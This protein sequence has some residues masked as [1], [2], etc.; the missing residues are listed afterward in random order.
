M[1]TTAALP[2]DI[3]LMNTVANVLWVGFGIALIAVVM[4]WVARLPLFAIHA[5]IVD[6]DVT[7]NS[8]TTI[9]ANAAPRLA[10]T[11]FTLDLDRAKQAFEAVPWVREAIV[12][13]VWPNRI[14]VHLE[15]HHPAAFWGDDKL[16]NTEGEVFEANLGDVEDDNLPTL[17]GPD[18]SSQ[19][20]LSLYR[21][22]EPVLEKLDTRIDTLNLSGRGSYQAELD[23]GATIEIGRGTE[24]ELV[25]R[26]QRFVRTL[27][28][29][30]THYGRSLQYADLRHA[31]GYAVRLK[32][33]TTTTD[34]QPAKPAVKSKPRTTTRDVPAKPG[35]H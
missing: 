1:D 23:N 18:G 28:E 30:T 4:A 19:S 24:D 32:G 7:R 35:R 15:E 25:A 33:I 29:V 10:G 9:R 22:V 21:R 5:V 2:A 3:R 31:D 6:G 34:A 26:T 14:A 17:S 20:M 16:V 27:G 12:R 11:F 8:V 13:R